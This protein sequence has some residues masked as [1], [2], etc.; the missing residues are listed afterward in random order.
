M[1]CEEKRTDYLQVIFIVCWVAPLDKRGIYKTR[2][3]LLI[4]YRKV[5]HKTT[6]G[7]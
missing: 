4:Q 2:V 6:Q 7:K 1:R 5:P 3:G